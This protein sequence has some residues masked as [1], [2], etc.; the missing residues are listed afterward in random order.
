MKKLLIIS[1]LASSCHATPITTGSPV[2]VA[3]SAPGTH[4]MH[5]LAAP[6][7]VGVDHVTIKLFSLDGDVEKAT[8]RLLPGQ[9]TSVQFQNLP[10]GV[11][12]ATAEAFSSRDDSQSFTQ[13][14]AQRST[15]EVTVASPQVT[16]S[17]PSPSGLNVALTLLDSQGGTASVN[18]TTGRTPSA[19]DAW[20]LDGAGNLKAPYSSSVPAFRFEKI[21]D[22]L[23]QAVVSLALNGTTT[24]PSRLSPQRLAYANG[25]G[26]DGADFALTIDGK[27]QAVTSGL[28]KPRGVWG[29]S[30]GDLYIADTN[31]HCIRKYANGA[32]TIIAGSGKSNQSGHKDHADAK[33]ASVRLDT[34]SAVVMAAN[35]DL[36][37]ADTANHCI[38]MVS[39]TNGSISTVIGQAKKAGFDGDGASATKAQLSSPRGLAF[40]ANGDLYIADSGN[41]RIRMVSATTGTISTVAGDGTTGVL[42]APEGISLAANG[43]LYIA[44]TGNHRIRQL[45]GGSLTTVAGT[46]VSGWSGDGGPALAAQLNSPKG[47]IVGV[48]GDLLIA[49]SGNHWLRRLSG[50][51]LTFVSGDGGR[52]SGSSGDGGNAEAAKW[53]D[54][55]G[56]WSGPTGDLYVADTG[57]GR[58]RVIR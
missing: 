7:L 27:T 36:Y 35:G 28:D 18:V 5:T 12:Y 54:P 55:I 57:N 9:G 21:P 30:Q 26:T 53:S 51:T 32:L 46:G 34:P 50:T 1:L 22:G 39:A 43:D 41:H 33:N 16:Y 17:T 49:D 20:L 24:L 42:K 56:L 19:Y 44:D 52:K 2:A 11:Y 4:G 23:F 48:G 37:I 47:V 58:I 40:A 10:D 14:G 3:F 8:H 31:A 15:N 38:R 13:G 6:D 45:S 29:T 25:V